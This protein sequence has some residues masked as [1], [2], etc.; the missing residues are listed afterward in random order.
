M[1]HPGLCRDRRP[2]TD[3]RSHQPRRLTTG[4]PAENRR[5]TRRPRADSFLGCG[6]GRLF[7]R[8]LDERLAVAGPDQDQDRDDA[9]GG[10]LAP[11][12]KAIWNPTPGPNRAVPR[13]TSVGTPD[14][15]ALGTRID[16]ATSISASPAVHLLRAESA[17]LAEGDRRLRQNPIP[18]ISP[19]RRSWPSQ[20]PTSCEQ[21]Q[22]CA[23]GANARSLAFSLGDPSRRDCGSQSEESALRSSF[24]RGV[25]KRLRHGVRDFWIGPKAP[26]QRTLKRSCGRWCTIDQQR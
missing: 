25:G 8:H 5:A 14:P 19:R 9:Q 22:R 6:D 2:R 13:L 23:S 20:Y 16:G 24:R 1:S 11:P 15:K 12:K 21:I 18:S 4:V 7:V 10:D 3:R 26:D 17:P